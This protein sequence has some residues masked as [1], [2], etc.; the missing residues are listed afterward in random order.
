[1]TAHEKT[2]SNL[3]LS[4]GVVITPTPLKKEV[5]NMEKILTDSIDEITLILLPTK[6]SNSQEWDKNRNVM[7]QTFIFL[8]KLK[9]VYGTT[10]QADKSKQAGYTDSLIFPDKPLLSISWH[11]IFDNMGVCVHFSALAWTMY[12]TRFSKTY[13]EYIN[14]AD[15][16]RMVQSEVYVTRLSRIDFVADYKNFP[17]SASPDTIYR[18]MIEEKLIVRNCENRKVV[19]KKEGLNKGG[20]Y[21]TVYLGSK[22]SNTRYFCRIYD[23]KLEQLQK[24]GHYYQEAMNCDSWVRHEVVFR[25]IYAQQITEELLNNVHT[26]DDLQSFIAQKITEKYQFYEADAS[27][28]TDYTKA[29]LEVVGNHKFP[30]LRNPSPRDNNLN[31][32]IRYLRTGSGLYSVLYKVSC[33]WG[34]D[35]E[36]KLLELFYSEYKEKYKKDVLKNK[37]IFLWL[38]KHQDNLKN[39]KLNDYF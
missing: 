8:S 18:G 1:M 15:F 35:A 24:M 30:L 11:K 37:D 12:Q 23:K 3:K 16:L 5:Q 36:K 7:I 26:D 29:L 21:Q 13:H 25:N 39:D 9:M 34:N 28:P 14:V 10:A 4:G 20:Y 17:S 19:Q 27:E 31:A 38:K 33:I 6:E 2:E 32:S 22:K